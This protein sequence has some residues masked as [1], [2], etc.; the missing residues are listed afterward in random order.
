MT[1]VAS[2]TGL[3]QRGT[4]YYL[5]I[6]LPVKHP[7]S[8]TYKNGRMVSS[9]GRCT[10]REAVLKGTIRRAEVLGG[11]QPR[12]SL[13]PPIVH[14]QHTTA[15][16]LREIYDRW[17]D[18]KP[19]SSDSLNTCLRSVT[20]YEEFTGNPP[21]HQ[22]TREQGDG[23]RTWL[24]QPERKTTSK[25]ARDRLTWVKS[26]LKYAARDLGLLERNPWEGI[27]ITTKTTNKR[28]PWTDS[29]L[30]TFFSQP[31]HVAHRLP[32]DKKAGSDAAYWIPLLGLYSGARVGEL[33]QL[34]LADVDTTGEFPLLSITDEGE[35][36]SVKSQAGVRKVP[37]HS[38][39]I[40]LGFLDYVASMKEQKET[41]LWPRLPTREGKP[42]G[43]FSQWFG[44]YR[45]SLGFG[46][47]PDFHCL[48]HTVRSQ[49]ESPRVSWR[50]IGLSQTDI[51]A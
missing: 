2:L 26:L 29:E 13:S 28:R 18:S 15:L 37:I 21:I 47:Y 11:F 48:R 42:G 43:Y 32:N 5:C 12:E 24:Q 30:M 16:L 6:V 31:L 14:Q 35:G 27:N 41:L 49:I 20:M 22:L 40:R 9:L 46:L 19:R 33:A 17:K 45:R 4:V 1:D 51:A 3:F 44:A 7:L 8:S 23:F 38:E 39:L 50:P 10:H 36:Q 25:T 34:R